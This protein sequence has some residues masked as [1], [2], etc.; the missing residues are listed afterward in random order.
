MSY[1]IHVIRE[2]DGSLRT[3]IYGDVPP[4]RHEISGH[5]DPQNYE[6]NLSVSHRLPNGRIRAS[7]SAQHAHVVEPRPAPLTHDPTE[8]PPDHA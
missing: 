3:Q 7:A 4:G 2:D 1:Q 8:H 5:Y 6:G